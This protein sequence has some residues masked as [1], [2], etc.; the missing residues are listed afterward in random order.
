M[1][2]RVVERS[3]DTTRSSEDLLLLLPRRTYIGGNDLR[4]AP[5]EKIRRVAKDGLQDGEAAKRADKG[6]DE[7]DPE[8]LWLRDQGKVSCPESL[9]RVCQ[10][11]WSLHRGCHVMRARL[12]DAAWRRR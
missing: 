7:P 9:V 5:L 3:D 8:R 4:V 6:Q 10:R 12:D 1:S 2:E 11:A